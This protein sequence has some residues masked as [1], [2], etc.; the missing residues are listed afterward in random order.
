[1]PTL[2]QL[3]FIHRRADRL[4][5]WMDV[6]LRGV[7]IP[8]PGKVGERVRVHVWCPARQ[9]GMPEG[10]QLKGHKF[11]VISLRFFPKNPCRLGNGLQM[12]FL[13]R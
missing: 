13:Q 7:H 9:A 8:M 10:V 1:M 3:R 2:F 6:A 12:L 11:G 5:L 4:F